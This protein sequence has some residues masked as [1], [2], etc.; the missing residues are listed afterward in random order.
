MDGVGEVRKS[1]RKGG[2]AATHPPLPPSANQAGLA[3]GHASHAQSCLQ[4]VTPPSKRRC[5]AELGVEAETSRHPAA[6]CAEH[7]ASR[8]MA[9]PAPPALP[10][11]GRQLPPSL[12]PWPPHQSAQSGPA[13][14]YIS[15]CPLCS[16]CRSL[17]SSSTG[18]SSGLSSSSSSRGLSSS[19]SSSSNH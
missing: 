11:A 16:S 12:P 19:S 9:R 5:T 4:A 17:S 7:V 3:G 15:P 18:S 2:V 6:A 8:V 13:P 10:A 14:L 1:R